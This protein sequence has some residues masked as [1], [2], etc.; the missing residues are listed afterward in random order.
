ML[1]ILQMLSH[2]PLKEFSQGACLRILCP[3]FSLQVVPLYTHPDCLTPRFLGESEIGLASPP[4]QYGQ[5]THAT[6]QA[7][8]QFKVLLPLGLVLSGVSSG[9]EQGQDQNLNLPVLFSEPK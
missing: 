8:G 5:S 7:P 9:L 2:S 4:A 6:S 1:G 3:S